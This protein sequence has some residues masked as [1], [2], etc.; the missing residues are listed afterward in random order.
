MT[1]AASPPPGY[2]AY[3]SPLPKEWQ[4]PQSI[5]DRVGA[6]A[7]PQRAILEEGH[8]LLILHEPPEPNVVERIPAFFWRAPSGEWRTCRRVMP[9]G[10]LTDFLAACE[11][12]LLRLETVETEAAT[13]A[14]YHSVLEGTAPLLRAIRGMHRALQQAREMVKADRDLINHRDRA[15]ALERTAELLLQDAQ[16]GLGFI[17]AKQSEAQ[18]ESAR[19]MAATAHRLNL[20]AALFLPLTAVASVLSMEVHSGLADTRENFYYI[21]GGGIGLGLIVALMLRRKG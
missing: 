7:G 11:A 3:R 14:S 19:R 10:N 13:A 5:R 12:R 1:P 17:A 4:I 6:E 18:A 21:I 9:A 8:L 20:M 2:S 15:A 16:F